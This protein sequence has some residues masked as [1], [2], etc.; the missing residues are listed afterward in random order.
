MSSKMFIEGI[1]LSWFP[2][3][4]FETTSFLPEPRAC[5]SSGGERMA[6]RTGSAAPWYGLTQ[7]AWV[8][9]LYTDYGKEHGSY[10]ILRLYGVM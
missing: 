6:L 3:A 7:H 5:Q 1:G 8:L 9:G 10:Y 2:L 4:S